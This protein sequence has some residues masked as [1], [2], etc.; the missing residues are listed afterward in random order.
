MNIF[1]S[2]FFETTKYD[3]GLVLEEHANVLV[4]LK[5]VS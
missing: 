1:S 3:V 5:H 4:V 2:M